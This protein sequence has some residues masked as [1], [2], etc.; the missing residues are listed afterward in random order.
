MLSLGNH[1]FAKAGWEFDHGDHEVSISESGLMQRE[2]EIL[3]LSDGENGTIDILVYNMSFSLGEGY[4]LLLG[5][6][7]SPT[8]SVLRL[9]TKRPASLTNEDLAGDWILTELS[10]E[11]NDGG[12]DIHGFET[13]SGDI[14]I[15]TDGSFTV[16]TGSVGSYSIDERRHVIVSLEGEIIDFGE[17]RAKIC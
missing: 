6:E 14:T 5:R 16:S 4:D 2:E 15:N 1:L 17:L 13:F 9:I 11:E 12:L 8:E 10:I 3:Q 7:V